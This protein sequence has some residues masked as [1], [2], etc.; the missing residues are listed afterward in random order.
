MSRADVTLDNLDI[1][2]L[3]MVVYFT[4]AELFKFNLHNEYIM[5]PIVLWVLFLSFWNCFLLKNQISIKKYYTPFLFDLYLSI[6][7]S[8]HCYIVS[9]RK[10]CGIFKN[11]II[12]AIF[13]NSEEK[14]QI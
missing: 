10:V 5:Q 11:K 6:A 3:I 4:Y 9:E 8:V 7:D 12:T 2:Y 1:F 14:I 13:A